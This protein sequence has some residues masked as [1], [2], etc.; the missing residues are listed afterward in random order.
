MAE[1]M[2]SA[3]KR[4]ASQSVPL[5]FNVEVRGFLLFKSVTYSFCKHEHQ[6]VHMMKTHNTGHTNSLVKFMF[7]SMKLEDFMN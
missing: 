1:N 6:L 3:A 5:T 2:V 4:F 7:R